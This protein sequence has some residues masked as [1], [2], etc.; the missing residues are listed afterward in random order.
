MSLLNY[1]PTS[2][3]VDK[4]IR[5][6][7]ETIDEAVLLAVHEPVRILKRSAQGGV[8]EE[9]TEQDLL[10][11]LLVESG[12]GSAVIVSI[13]GPS[14]VGKSH[15]VR[16]LGAQLARHARRDDLVV[17]Q[18]PK[19]ASLRRVVELILAP[20]RGPEYDELRGKL[21]IAIESISIDEAPMRLA[22][23]LTLQLRRKSTEWL[24][25]LR[26]GDRSFKE[27]TY[28][29][30]RLQNLL[31]D[32]VFRD[33]MLNRALVR[34]VERA[35]AGAG[36]AA[37]A[38]QFEVDDLVW[39]DSEQ[40]TGATADARDYYRVLCDHDGAERATAVD[41]LSS[42]IDEALRMV[43]R[44]EQA[45][46]N[47]TIEDLVGAI[48]SQLL[49]ENK[50]LVLL[51]E[52]FAALSGIQGPLLSMIIAQSDQAGVRERAPIRTALAVTDGFLPQRDTIMTRAKGEWVIATDYGS[53]EAL[54]ERLIGMAGRYLNAARWGHEA[55]RRQFEARDDQSR[56]GLYGWVR[57]FSDEG[58]DAEDEEILRA[59]GRTEAGHFL[60]P[61]NETALQSFCDRELRAD[62]K[63]KFNP[64]T[65]I[66]Q[67]L[68]ET[69]EQRHRF[70]QREFPPVGFKG[71]IL[72]SG[73]ETEL[74]TWQKPAAVKA[75]MKPVL[76]HWCGNPATLTGGAPVPENLFD[77]FA[78][79]YPFSAKHVEGT[80]A[81]RTAG[82]ST[83]S[84]PLGVGD[85]ASVRVTLAPTVAPGRVPSAFEAEIERL[86]PGSRPS[87]GT[88]RTIRNLI[89]S[90]IGR[91]LDLSA[92]DTKRV[93]GLIFVPFAEHGN[94]TV[95]P[96]FRIGEEADKVPGWIRKA[97]IGLERWDK[98]KSWNY[99]NAEDDYGVVQ[100]LLDSLEPSV[101]LYFA[102]LAKRRL[103]STLH[104][105][106]RHNL[107]LG[108][109]GSKSLPGA[110]EK[111]FEPLEQG[112]DEEQFSASD[113]TDRSPTL[114]KALARAR[115]ARSELQDVILADSACFQ[116]AGTKPQGIHYA[117]LV[118]ARSAQG[119]EA[120]LNLPSLSKETSDH[121][122]ELQRDFDRLVGLYRAVVIRHGQK[123]VNALGP[124]F[125]KQTWIETLKQ[126]LGEAQVQAQLPT[127]V[128]LAECNALLDALGK[129]ALTDLLTH[130]RA[131]IDAPDS[132]DSEEQLRV[133]GRVDVAF[134]MR[135]VKQVGR[136]ETVL[137][138]VERNL[139]GAEVG[140]TSDPEDVRAHF[141][142]ELSLA[143][144]MLG[145]DV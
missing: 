99:P 114:G 38:P 104:A 17:I 57:P 62:G 107:L 64:R 11:A 103:S 116:G 12:D 121:I 129:A 133:L 98:G 56:A 119:D 76:I 105:A 123:L 7:A 94:P 34:I 69:L 118:A 85:G 40:F 6:E 52:D 95:A 137:N 13:T 92:V 106:Y 68:R 70:E 50:E 63:V 58:L 127:D 28:H 53:T 81:K 60:F 33:G 4:C 136:L 55:I 65:F 113:A 101:Q 100:R 140:F 82:A 1:W 18:I 27:K 24:A 61:F 130:T 10:D 75:R 73:A 128:R 51:I 66:N 22:T 49:K 45:L 126:V 143:I 134:L 142:D 14:G 3:E 72:L 117:M 26:S 25:A 86:G 112:F 41:V 2:A 48:R 132:A 102:D 29:A 19:T 145:E 135:T 43:F 125:D 46:G 120:A 30:Q 115:K 131:A 39:S 47:Y 44:F 80:G 21:A 20:L 89:G 23:E 9:K 8:V 77:A 96:W 16:W 138:G 144:R 124:D 37:A 87:Q 78:L 88:A 108:L 31:S 109:G 42:V 79:P 5:T 71:G 36:E 139:R 122:V 83:G 90:A 15:M 84:K 74:E 141:K 32:P 35:V 67:V 59:F 93:T 91:R 111:L 110:F 54:M 97:L